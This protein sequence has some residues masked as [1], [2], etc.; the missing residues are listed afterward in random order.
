MNELEREF[1]WEVIY[2][3]DF[4]KF[5]TSLQH[6][7]P[8]G[9]LLKSTKTVHNTDYYLDDTSAALAARKMALRIR[10]TDGVFE[11]TLKNQGEVKDGQVTRK[12]TTIALPGVRTFAAAIKA[13]HAREV[14]EGINVKTV[15]V[16]FFIK[17]Q[18]TLYLVH[19]VE[20]AQYEVAFDDFTITVKGRKLMMK[21]IEMELKTGNVTDFE[22]FAQELTRRSKLEFPKMSKVK[23]AS[24]MLKWWK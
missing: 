11:L 23:T 8:A 24:E 1:K 15:E 21:E 6:A 13:L 4:R 16:I 2:P 12:E 19:P 10:E 9:T 17:N 20:G 18:R 22:K 3:S 5:K 7:L 14:F